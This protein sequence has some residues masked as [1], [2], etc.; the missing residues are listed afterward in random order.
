MQWNSS[1]KL[2]YTWQ[3][4]SPVPGRRN[5]LRHSLKVNQLCMF[6]DLWPSRVWVNYW[7]VELSGTCRWDLP[8][9]QV[10]WVHGWILKASQIRLN[11]LQKKYSSTVM[12]CSTWILST[13]HSH[14]SLHTHTHTLIHWSKT[15]YHLFTSLEPPY[16][17]LLRW[18][19]VDLT[20]PYTHI[21][22]HSHLS[23]TE[24]GL[25]VCGY[26]TTPSC[27]DKLQ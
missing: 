24:P 26:V 18:C 20:G 17:I 7:P 2:W 3:V 8:Y 19:Q 25:N 21:Q 11:R 14:S 13:I 4:C 15:M 9:R 22:A 5:D 23:T 1:R 16:S 10:A 27:A 6:S 12:Q